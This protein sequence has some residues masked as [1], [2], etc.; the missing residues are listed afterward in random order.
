MTETHLQKEERKFFTAIL[1]SDGI[2]HF[3][4]KE[5][6]DY[7]L[8]IAL[9]QNELLEKFGG[10]KKMP[11]MISM[12]TYNP[13]N[14][15]S[16]KYGASEEGRRYMKTTAIVINSLALRLGA[17]FYLNFFKPKVPTKIFNLENEAVKWLTKYT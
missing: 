2:V 16:M 13:P 9:E 12:E 10:G 14:S 15:E 5:M 7:S 3:T 4:M 8:E 11:V 17:N 6:E 1:R